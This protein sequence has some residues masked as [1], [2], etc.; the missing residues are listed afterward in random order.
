[1]AFSNKFAGTGTTLSCNYYM[2]SF[3]RTNTDA[4]TAS[5]RKNLDNTSLTLADS[6]ALRRAVKQLGS[7]SFSEDDDAN[8]RNS[9]KA[10]ITTYN[11]ALDSLADSSDHTLER[12]M[13]Q[14]KS[15]TA[16]YQKQ[17]DKVGI[18]VGEDGRL[19]DRDS[20]LDTADLSK[21]KE[22][23]ASDSSF[24][25]RTSVYA[26]RM[27]RRSDALELA[28]K[29]QELQKIAASKEPDSNVDLDTLL[30]TGIGQNVNITI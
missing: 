12:N 15:L 24:M 3:Y 2:R 23:F 27:E 5:K 16:E 29:N 9:V 1:M 6:L 22:L 4:H 21:F 19:T 13:K 10:F 17:L 28:A 7:S 30:N 25:Q 14:L 26:R 18:T 8:I 20:L 11:N